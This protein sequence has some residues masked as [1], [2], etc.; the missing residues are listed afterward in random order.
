MKGDKI[1]LAGAHGMV[2]NAMRRTL[3]TAG[4]CDILTPPRWEV[5]WTNLDDT[6]LY[7]HENR[8]TVVIV[9]AAKVGGILYND[10]APLSF[11]RENLEIELNILR[12]ASEYCNVRKLLFMGSSCIYPR[13]AGLPIKETSLMSGPLEKTNEAYALAKIVGVKMCEFISRSNPSKQFFSVMP[14]NLYGIRDTYDP[15]R[16]HVIPAMIYKFER[17]KKRGEKSV[18]LPGTGT[19]LREFLYADDLA[20]AC[21][22]LLRVNTPLPS[23]INIGSPEEVT[24]LELAEMV[25]AATGFKGK[26]LFDG[27]ARLDGTRRKRLDCS[28]L[29]SLVHWVPEVSLLEGLPRAVRD[30]RLSSAYQEL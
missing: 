28:L 7:F 16:S 14:T 8:P 22:A 30:F 21:L 19:A 5:D 25:K 29:H 20:K 4:F 11:L 18:T 15:L 27:D 12:A 23:V 10:S 6:C 9:A 2:G 1:L 24:I 17:A 26:L 3:T 13:D